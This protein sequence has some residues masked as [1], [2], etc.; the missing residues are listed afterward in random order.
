[1]TTHHSVVV[2][3]LGLDVG[4]QSTKCIIYDPSAKIIRG[5]GSSSN[6]YVPTTTGRAEQDPA[7]WIAAC[8]EA[9]LQAQ[10]NQTTTITKAISVS[11]QQHGLVVLDRD[12]KIIR[13]AK[14]WC[15][16]E[17][18][19]EAAHLSKLFNTTIVPSFTITKL[20]WLKNNEPDNYARVRH[21]LLPHDYVNWWLTGRFCMEASDASGT[22]FFDPVTKQWDRE[23][24]NAVDPQIIEW[25]P[26]TILGPTDVVGT[27]LPSR[28]QELGLLTTN[29]PQDSSILVGPGG[30][31]N[32]MSALG[33]GAV[34]AGSMVCSLGTSGTL[35]GPSVEPVHDTTGAI[36]AFCDATGQALPLLC[37]I[38][39][40]GAT[41]EVRKMVY[42][43]SQPCHSTGD[44]SENENDILTGNVCEKQ[45]AYLAQLAAE[46]PAGSSG[47]TFLP[48]F[49]GERTPNW[50]SASGTIL[51]LRPGL[52]A[53][54][55]L[56]YR[57]AMEGATFSLLYGTSLLPHKLTELYVV[58]G[59]S[60]NKAWTRILADSFQVPLTIPHQAETAAL[61]AAFQA[62]AVMLGVDELRTFIKEHA[63]GIRCCDKNIVVEPNASAK[64]AYAEAFEKFVALGRK[65]FV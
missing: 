2:C 40:T 34:N 22:G 29:S 55:G 57:A 18:A 17:S 42:W 16:V 15:D 10:K 6:Y 33:C 54:P 37:T 45:H 4:T 31:D 44:E 28:A 3:S 56:L 43:D 21:V 51:G 36:C 26:S 32:A 24:I 30:G 23:R 41:E 61:G 19:A 62:A 25:L 14:L 20:L 50:P 5:E 11:G 35:F 27:V 7:I 46:E 58:G 39:C 53:R 9:I 8:K 1:M 49:S 60:K 64:E 63:K 52:L 65:C 59:G 38:N 48:Y 13:P 47:V 12:N